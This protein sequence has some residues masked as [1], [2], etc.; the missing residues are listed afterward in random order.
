MENIDI[1]KKP[2][3]CQDFDTHVLNIDDMFLFSLT[4]CFDTGDKFYIFWLTDVYE[5]MLTSIE[6]V[7]LQMT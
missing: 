5:N 7:D 2:R 3:Y 6:N 1:L 4:F